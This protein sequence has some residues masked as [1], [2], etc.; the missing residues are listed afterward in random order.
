M[1][2]AFVFPGQGSQAP[3]MGLDWVQPVAGANDLYGWASAC[4]G[5]DLAGT[6]RDASADELRQTYIAQPAIFCVSVAALQALQRAGVEPAF[7]A[8]HSLG[9]FSALVAAGS[10]SFEA[11]T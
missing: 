4:L 2:I 1:S 11:A 9:E 3:G 7:V 8:G 6:L 5:W 10:L